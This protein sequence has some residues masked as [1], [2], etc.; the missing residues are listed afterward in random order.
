MRDPTR[1]RKTDPTVQPWAEAS[2][3][4]SMAVS[5]RDRDICDMVRLSLRKGRVMLAFQPVMQLAEPMG[6]AF[7]EALLRVLDRKGRVIPARDFMGV[8]EKH[9]LG[10]MLD[11]MALDLGLKTLEDVPALRLS[12]NMSAHSIGYRPWQA[13]LD[14]RLKRDP[15][16]GERLI[17]E[18]T[19]QSANDMPDIVQAFMKEM[20]MRGVSFALDNFGDGYSSLKYLRDFY[21]DI[22]KIDGGLV[23]NMHKNPD[24]RVLTQAIISLARHFDM[25]TVAQNVENQS[26]AE[27]L[28]HLGIDCLQGYYF[29]A[30]TL[31]PVWLDEQDSAR[32][33]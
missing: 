32:S 9:E 29:G 22:L 4:L 18:I 28:A 7:H 12:I 2:S 10:R 33:A 8:A 23:H 21:F 16:I 19:E 24:N 3:P 15:T 13:V 14:T 26:D 11:S 6:I 31:A 20:H 1:P 27:L 17:L 30:P 5:A 25:F